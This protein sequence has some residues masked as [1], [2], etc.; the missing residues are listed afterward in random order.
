MY[1]IPSR[2]LMLLIWFWTRESSFWLTQLKL[3][4]K[5]VYVT[6]P[7][8]LIFISY[9]RLPWRISSG[10]IPCRIISPKISVQSYLPPKW[11]KA[12]VGYRL[13]C[14]YKIH[15]VKSANGVSV[16]ICW[17]TSVSEK[18]NGAQ[19]NFLLS[20]QIWQG[21]F[22]AEFHWLVVIHSVQKTWAQTKLTLWF[23][24]CFTSFSGICSD[25]KS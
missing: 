5:N 8:L 19:V 21:S 4:L 17:S 6:P 13:F 22:N 16:I 11:A 25:S 1:Q 23:K 15:F 10:T 14:S 24:Y 12:Y 7:G 18:L 20:P 3:S 2:I 9:R